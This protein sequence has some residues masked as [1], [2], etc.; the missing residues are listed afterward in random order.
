M[1]TST[2]FVGCESNVMAH[3]SK[4]ATAAAEPQVICTVRVLNDDRTWRHRR[5]DEQSEG[6][7]I[8]GKEPLCRAIQVPQAVRHMPHPSR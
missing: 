7:E 4:A 6:L 8:K 5:A 3:K 2:K 1:A